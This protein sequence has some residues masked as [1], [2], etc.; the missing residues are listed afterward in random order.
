[1]T[2]NPFSSETFKDV[3]RK[4]FNTS[5]NEI[6][7]SFVKPISFYK[8]QLVP[9]FV[10][11][12]NKLTN[13]LTYRIDNANLDY[14]NKVFLIRDIPSYQ[15]LQE[16]AKTSHLKLKKVFQYEGYITRVSNYESIDVYLNTIYK[17][18]TRSKLRRNIKRLESNF[19]VE[20]SM[21]HGAIS[22]ADFDFVF[23]NF[24]KLFEKRYANKGEPCGELN[25]VIWA[26][27]TELA[28]KMINEGTAS[29]FVIYTDGKPIGITFSYH[30][31]AIL[32]E[33]LTVFDID[34]YKYNIGHTTIL[35][36]LEWSFKNE[37]AI[38]DYTQGDFDYKK[39]WS[40]DRYQ[41]YYHI[42]YD[43]KSLKCRL[44]AGLLEK[45]FRFKRECR[46]RN[47]SSKV[48]S[49]NHWL[50]DGNTN[51]AVLINT[52]K[53]EI[54][55]DKKLLDNYSQLIDI[56]LYKYTSQRKALYDYLYLNPE[57]ARNFKVCLYKNDSLLAIG[58]NSILKIVKDES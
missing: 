9:C 43:S 41:T 2:K 8:H 3:W 37:I 53:V 7:F 57:P 10:N 13:G 45:Y 17:S 15:E 47:Y 27:Y 42:L 58:E 52:H 21:H 29:L 51:K 11:L 24:Y 12:G 5:K 4:H 6:T 26:F 40:D 50:L 35:K 56:D 22:R 28:F 49:F 14:K 34:F 25:P 32:V 23:E 36:M 38:F 20:Y 55:S 16:P 48:H 46:E 44:T 33:A 31:D 18:N 19:K 39:R 30:F 1:M 54:V